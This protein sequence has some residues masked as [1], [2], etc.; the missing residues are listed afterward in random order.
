L[1][2]D[3]LNYAKL[4]SKNSVIDEIIENGDFLRIISKENSG[5]EEIKYLDMPI[6]VNIA[7]H[8]RSFIEDKS[9]WRDSVKGLRCSGWEERKQKIIEYFES[10]LRENEFPTP[11]SHGPLT[12]V[13][14]GGFPFCKVGNH[15]LSASKV[16]LAGK[17]GEKAKLK[18]VKC[19]RHVI[20]HKILGVLKS[21][22][23]PGAKLK[24]S[25]WGKEEQNLKDQKLFR[26]GYRN[27]LYLKQENEKPKLYIFSDESDCI[28]LK[29]CLRYFPSFVKFNRY[30]RFLSFEY[31]ELSRGFIETIIDETKINAIFTNNK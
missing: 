8:N 11:G 17:H 14:V 10:E 5:R 4:V 24:Y 3:L 9:S 12:I 27:L 2:A 1:K 29:D 13:Y 15:R 20:K 28:E 30:S 31:E 7:L 6:S 26:S 25:F 23:E 16:W 22:L 19:V 18:K 21:S